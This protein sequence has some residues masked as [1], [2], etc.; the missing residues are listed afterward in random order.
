MSVCR[1]RK[2][3][4]P[5]NGSLKP[6]FFTVIIMYAVTML[7]LTALTIVVYIFQL[8][9]AAV[10]IGII[11]IYAIVGFVGG[12]LFGTD[13]K[14]GAWKVGACYLGVWYAIVVF[15]GQYIEKDFKQLLLIT[16]IILTSSKLGNSFSK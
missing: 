5:H 15:V 3:R 13:H 7:L 9:A 2:H 12:I 14:R 11:I 16:V 8:K 1:K 10:K 6:V 4:F